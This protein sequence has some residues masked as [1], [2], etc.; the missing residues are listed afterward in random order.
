MTIDKVILLISA[1]GI[2][3]FVSV[4]VRAASADRKRRQK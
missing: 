3:Y 4:I 2:I 1:I